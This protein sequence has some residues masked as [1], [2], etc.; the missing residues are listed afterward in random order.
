MVRLRTFGIPSLLFIAACVAGTTSSPPPSPGDPAQPTSAGD[1]LPAAPADQAAVAMGMS[2]VSSNA[3]GVPRLMRSL[4]PRASVAGAAPAQAARD[5]VAA[6]APLWVHAAP[7]AALSDNGTQRLRSGATVVKLT[8]AIG[9]VPIHA[10]EL[11]VMM[12]PDGALAAVSGT[13]LPSTVQP[14]FGSS[15]RQALE[16][17]LDQLYGTSRVRPSVSELAEQG[18]WQQLAVTADPQLQVTRAR[19]R[20]ELVDVGGILTPAWALE[21]FGTGV[22]DVSGQLSARP[23]GHRYLIGDAD[24]AILG[25]A[26]LI[27]ADAFVYRAFAEPTGNRRPLD[28]VL[29]SVAPHPTGVPGGAV[30]GF[31]DANLVVMEAFNEPHDKWLPDDATTTSGNNA[32]AFADFDAS[33][34]FG[35]GDTRPVVRAGRVLNYTYDPALEPLASTDQANASTVNMFFLTN[36]M[37]DWWYDSGFTEA[38][39]NAQV[40]NYGR[41]GIGGDPI[42]LQAQTG[43]AFGLRNDAFM[44]TPADGMSPQM[45]MLLWN[46]GGAGPE[47]D[48]GLDNTVVAHEWGHYLHNRLATCDSGLQCSGMS[49]GWGDFNALLMM[50]RDGDNREGSYALG[51][52]ALAN[53]AFDAAYFGIRRYPYSL[54]RSKNDLSYRH[55]S[56]GAVLPA[57][58]AGFPSG[59][60]SDTHN[61]GEVWASLL[62]ESFNV[63]IDAHGVP[64]ARRRMSDYV[65]AGLLLTPPEAT[66]LEGRDAILAAAGALDSDDMVLLAAAFA[67]R[68]AGSCAVGPSN[69]T[70]GNAGAVDSRTLAARLDA[71]GMSLSD[72]GISCDH[73]GILDPG[74]SGVLHLTVANG[75]IVDAEAVTITATS[76]SPSVRLGA[77]IRIPTLHPFQSVDL[78]IPVTLLASAPRNTN[79]TIDVRLAGDSTCSRTGAIVSLTVLTGIDEAATGS[80]SDG[81]EARHGT[82]WTLTGEGAATLWTLTADA[83]RNHFWFGKN[84]ARPSDIQLVSPVLQVS[85]S[86]SFVVSLSHAY[87]LEE[88]FDGGV[89]ELS[90]DAGASWTDVTEFGVDPGYVGELSPGGGNAL[91]NRVAFTG[92]SPGFPA[93]QPLTLDF[94]TRLAGQSVQ[95]RF[96]I[97]SDV[98]VALSGW[99]IDDVAVSGITN[100]PFPLFVPEPSTCTARKAVADSAVV[101]TRTA[102]ITSLRA[103]DAAVC[104][105]GDTP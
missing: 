54:D 93:R 13:L 87:V 66:L 80:T 18:G 46:T 74:E 9:G 22:R 76:A 88:G 47:R 53:G 61:T 98:T 29:E 95:L 2:I 19:A 89:I 48:G 40:D 71:S 1:D 43:A 73:D 5:H 58:T 38:T 62:W 33:G 42:I 12:Y 36:W 24:Q 90:S 41:G 60:N 8:Q 21:V 97:G 31:I 101:A 51:T 14:R 59:R 64:A 68:G 28:G 78:A 57:D 50:L 69:A 39:G 75:G 23:A 30:P 6:L 7:P 105:A 91:E 20:R 63:L 70:P 83:S 86:E 84:L 35:P 82:P 65:V 100:A 32:D 85:R 17:A 27:K 72:D 79:V 104:I 99:T 102:P 81:F 77:P 37:H 52:Y 26:D 25:D 49:E 16:T 92:V 103:L 96:R 94:G 45:S 11:R 4:S 15:P 34:T 67:N 3:A 55:I 56:D 10:A 44:G